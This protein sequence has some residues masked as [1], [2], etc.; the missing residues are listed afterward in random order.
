MSR[1]RI[2][3]NIEDYKHGEQIDLEDSIAE[4]KYMDEV[5]ESQRWYYELVKGDPKKR[6]EQEWSAIRMLEGLNSMLIH[7]LYL[8]TKK[9]NNNG[10]QKKTIKKTIKKENSQ[11]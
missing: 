7:H 5:M 8:F 1:K 9:H 2:N 10:L 4:K 6:T 3:K 11:K